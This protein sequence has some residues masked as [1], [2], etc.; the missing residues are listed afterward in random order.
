[1]KFRSSKDIRKLIIGISKSC[2]SA[3]K[4]FPSPSFDSLNG[5]P[6]QLYNTNITASNCAEIENP[7][8]GALGKL[9][10]ELRIEIYELVAQDH[11]IPLNDPICLNMLTNFRSAEQSLALLRVSKQLHGEFKAVHKKHAWPTILCYFA[12]RQQDI[13]AHAEK[14]LCLF[15]KN[16]LLGRQIN[17]LTI[18]AYAFGGGEDELKY[19][20]LFLKEL[21]APP[22]H[23]KVE[24]SITHDPAKINHAQLKKLRVILYLTSWTMTRT[25]QMGSDDSLGAMC[26]AIMLGSTFDGEDCP[27]RF[28][29]LENLELRIRYTS[30]Y[31]A[32]QY[33]YN[34]CRN[35]NRSYPYNQLSIPLATQYRLRKQNR[36]HRTHY[37]EWFDKR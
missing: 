9:P 36:V 22:P 12:K 8:L 13:V 6:Q 16:V 21:L 34:F 23:T 17:R 24:A 30:R 1:M 20:T 5:P 26:H 33:T 4:R 35:L 37:L 29:N 10:A 15:D 11:T 3:N 25:L 2:P 32:E 7:S 31:G 19:M 27:R 18:V 14:A 28:E